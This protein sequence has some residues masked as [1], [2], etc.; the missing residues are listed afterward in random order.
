ML[1]SSACSTTGGEVAPLPR[2][3]EAQ[4]TTGQFVVE[5]GRKAGVGEW[6][7][8]AERGEQVEGLERG[9]LGEGGIGEVGDV[10]GGELVAREEGGDVDSRKALNFSRARSSFEESE[11][12]ALMKKQ[13]FEKKSLQATSASELS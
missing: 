13:N 6:I 2:L 11:L 5:L 10:G 8:E 7:G 1:T 9:D 4:F 3:F 12:T